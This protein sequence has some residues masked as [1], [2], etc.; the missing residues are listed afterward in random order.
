MQVSH[1]IRER[2][3]SH[4]FL[5]EPVDADTVGQIIDLA[6]WSPSWANTQSW[7]VYVIS[8]EPLQRIKA[9]LT[10]LDA[11]NEP[12]APDIPAQTL[13]PSY[14]AERMSIRRPPEA[15]GA[16]DAG[17]AGQ[18]AWELYGAPCL[19][20][21]AI[22]AELE[23][24]YACFDAGL[25]AQTFCLAAEDRGFATCIMATAV[26]YADVLHAEIPDAAGKRFV[27]GIAFGFSDH[28]AVVNRNERNRVEIEDIA[29]FLDDVDAGE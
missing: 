19:V 2:R 5:A 11:A 7:N 13:W 16:T 3:S 29:T 21:L 27:V 8:G 10:L 23:P 9:T 26:R 25:F 15:P 22:D 18:S 6:K 17:T 14:L 28:T 12:P 24:A 20:L 4:A 1:A